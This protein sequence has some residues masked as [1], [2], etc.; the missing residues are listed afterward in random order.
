N[1]SALNHYVARTQSFLQQGKADNDVLLY[2]PIYDKYSDPGRDLLLHF[3]GMKPGFSGTPFELAADT[4][5]QKGYA[6]DYIS[7][8]QILNLKDSANKIATGG[9][10]YQTIILPGVRFMKAQTVQKLFGLAKE[11]A[12]V[13]VYKNLP[14]E[15]PGYGELQ[16]HEETFNK[17]IQQLNFVSTNDSEIKLATVGKGRFLISNN[18]QQLLK[19]ASIRREGMTDK[20]LEFARRQNLAGSEYYFIAN[21][22]GQFIN[23][24]ITLQTKASGVSLYNPMTADSG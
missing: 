21:R 6:F 11:G 2:F 4:M 3:D 16:Q 20:N 5:Q 9:V 19:Y 1:F 17:L 13:L 14:T 18:L 24:W 23:E 12:T 15:V 22:S 7:D 8:R 10:A